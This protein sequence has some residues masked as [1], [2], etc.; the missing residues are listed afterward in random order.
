[1]QRRPHATTVEL[2]EQKIAQTH[3]YIV[4]P[5]SID[6]QLWFNLYNWTLN[7][8]IPS[9][10]EY[11]NSSESTE[12]QRQRRLAWEKEPA[13]LWKQ[14]NNEKRD[15]EVG[16]SEIGP[17]EQLKLS[18][19]GNLVSSVEVIKQNAEPGQDRVARLLHPR[20]N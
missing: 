2:S 9:W 11:N 14:H 16:E 18:S 7:S 8:V 17:G 3:G 1:M 10:S 4:R 5:S 15:M 19:K 13:T 12:E 6:I 20:V